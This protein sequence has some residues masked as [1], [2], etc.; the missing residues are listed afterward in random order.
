MF[1]LF[2]LRSTAQ[3]DLLAS[4]LNHHPPLSGSVG[5]ATHWWRPW[6]PCS[7]HGHGGHLCLPSIPLLERTLVITENQ[8]VEIMVK[9]AKEITPPDG[10]SESAFGIPSLPLDTQLTVY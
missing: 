8:V 3:V 4:H 1:R 5:L 9:L 7:N 10:I 6:T 2:Q